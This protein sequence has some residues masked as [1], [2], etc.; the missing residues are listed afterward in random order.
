MRESDP[1]DL[2]GEAHVSEAKPKTYAHIKRLPRGL[3]HDR[4][5]RPLRAL[6]TRF[7]GFPLGTPECN[8]RG[9][10]GQPCRLPSPTHDIAALKASGSS[11]SHSC[12][13]SRL[14][15]S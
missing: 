12:A 11:Q 7:S 13:C 4:T 5:Q 3:P 9:G 2:M 8:D 10:R 6:I 14:M 1:L 15:D